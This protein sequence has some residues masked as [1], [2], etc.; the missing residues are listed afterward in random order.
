MDSLL[1][2]PDYI[3]YYLFALPLLAAINALLIREERLQTAVVGLIACALFGFLVYFSSALLWPLFAMEQAFK[4]W[5]FNLLPRVPINFVIEPWGT[6]FALLTCLLW[7]LTIMYSYGYLKA[8]K[9]KH[10]GRFHACF[11]LAIFAVLG[12]AFSGNLIT[13]FI[14]YE[15]LT[16]ATYPLVTHDQTKE[17]IRA[18]R[19]YLAYLLG[20]S[21]LLFLPAIIFTAQKASTFNF[22]P[23]GIL[24]GNITPL[25]AGIL[26]LVYAYGVGKSALMPLHRWLP[27]AMVA[28][29]PVSALLHAVAVVNGGVFTFIKIGVYVFGVEFFFQLPAAHWLGVA[30]CTTV[31]VASIQALRTHLIKTLLAYSTISQLATI[32]MMASIATAPALQA[33]AIQFVSHALGKI[34]LFFV[35]GSIYTTT[36]YSTIEECKGLARRMPYSFA[37]LVVGAMAMIGMPP[38]LG[39]LAKWMM[40]SAALDG[41]H[42]WICFT[43]II[44]TLLNAFYFLRWIFICCEKPDFEKLIRRRDTPWSMRA[45]L[46][47]TAAASLILF[48]YPY[49]V[50]LLARQFS[51]L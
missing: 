50:L 33:V 49:P 46:L 18:G 24:E 51:V 11:A 23:S 43:L 21:M 26:L 7:P 47:I 6:L 10:R 25:A 14:F 28:P 35:A 12:I 1:S 38:T 39:L 27:E 8:T 41:M 4:I 29:A 44:S 22:L 45:A 31:I 3:I 37:A 20:T 9:S 16:L 34:T 15:L 36:Q 2:T 32:L 5:H 17:A 40:F 48:F 30:C 19:V 42:I 13:L